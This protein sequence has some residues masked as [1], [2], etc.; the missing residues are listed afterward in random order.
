VEYPFSFALP[1]P[2][3]LPTKRIDPRIRH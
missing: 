2:P 3:D 1:E